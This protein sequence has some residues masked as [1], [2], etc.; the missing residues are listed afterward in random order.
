MLQNPHHYPW[1]HAPSPVQDCPAGATPPRGAPSP[2]V[3]CGNCATRGP[4]RDLP[5]GDVATKRGNCIIRGATRRRH[6]DGR[7]LMVQ[8]PHHYP[9]CHAPSPV[10]DRP[11]GADKRRWGV[12]DGALLHGRE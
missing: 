9:W 8:N 12:A 1:C 6:A 2:P 11:T 10:Q 4:V 3:N 7:L 5:A